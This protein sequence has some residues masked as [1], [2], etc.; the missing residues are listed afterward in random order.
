M[1]ITLHTSS[2]CSPLHKLSVNLLPELPDAIAFRYKSVPAG[3]L[4][5]LRSAQKQISELKSEAAQSQA[6]TLVTQAEALPSGD[7]LL[8][9]EVA[10]VD[11]K[12]LQ[13]RSLALLIA[14][15]TAQ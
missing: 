11:A 12:S 1:S 9:A 15:S 7:K 14:A 3:L 6:L 5:E 10:N 13:V 4:E 8:A 2:Q